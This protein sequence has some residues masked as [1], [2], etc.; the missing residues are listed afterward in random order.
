MVEYMLFV[1]NISH[2]KKIKKLI[3]RCY[4]KSHKHWILIFM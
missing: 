3:V 4:V 2:F 1:M